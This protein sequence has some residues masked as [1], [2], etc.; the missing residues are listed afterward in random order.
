LRN[1]QV[2]MVRFL[3]DPNQPRQLMGTILGIPQGDALTFHD[4]QDLLRQIYILLENRVLKPE[5]ESKDV[6]E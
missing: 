4:E 2:F 6:D 5:L 1:V 3:L